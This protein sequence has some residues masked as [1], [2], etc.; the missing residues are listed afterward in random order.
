MEVA[1]N[2][3]TYKI[4]SVQ[5]DRRVTEPSFSLINECIPIKSLIL[6][7]FL[8]EWLRRALLI[9]VETL[10]PG[11]DSYLFEQFTQFKS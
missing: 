1:R 9:F 11:S 5:V 10:M 4:N 8:T 7:V 3:L 2:S 6:E